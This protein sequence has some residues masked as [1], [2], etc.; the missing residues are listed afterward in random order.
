[1]KTTDFIKQ[2]LQNVEKFKV[3][4][5]PQKWTNIYEIFVKFKLHTSQSN[6]KISIPTF[7]LF[8]EE[9][10]SKNKKTKYLLTS[11]N[12]NQVN[13]FLKIFSHV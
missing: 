10:L 3:L 8:K 11:V 13:Q 1:M 2:N 12:Q 7:E 4:Y 9:L 6:V 5:S